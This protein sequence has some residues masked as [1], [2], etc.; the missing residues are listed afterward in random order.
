M[1]KVVESLKII[2][3]PTVPNS[4]S[5]MSVVGSFY[6]FMKEHLIINTNYDCHKDIK[7]TIKKKWNDF[8]IEKVDLI[9]IKDYYEKWLKFLDDCMKGLDLSP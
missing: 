2:L 7:E 5:L 4:P 6:S 9:K 8:I 1:E 3:V